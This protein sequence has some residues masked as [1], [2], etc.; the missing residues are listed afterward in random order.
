LGFIAPSLWTVNEY[1]EA[2][3]AMIAGALPGHL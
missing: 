2:L 3:R 1:G